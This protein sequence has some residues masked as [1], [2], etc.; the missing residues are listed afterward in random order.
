MDGNEQIPKRNMFGAFASE[1][2]GV[3]GI[4]RLSDVVISIEIDSIFVV[5]PQIREALALPMR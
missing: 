4:C 5:E 3:V 2:S 1:I